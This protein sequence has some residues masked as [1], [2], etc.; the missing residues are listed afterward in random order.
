MTFVAEWARTMSLR[1]ANRANFNADDTWRSDAS[2]VRTPCDGRHELASTTAVRAHA[3]ADCL[4]H[5]RA[6]YRHRA[7]SI[8][9]LP[10][11]FPMTMPAVIGRMIAAIATFLRVD[12]MT[13]AFAATFILILAACPGEGLGAQRSETA[14]PNPSTDYESV[15]DRIRSGDDR[16]PHTTS[17]AWEQGLQLAVLRIDS[18][19]LGE[20]ASRAVNRWPAAQGA[21]E[22][23]WEWARVLV[24]LVQAALIAQGHDPGRPDGLMGPKTMLAMVAWSAASGPAWDGSSE[25]SYVRGLADNVAHLLHGTLQTL[26]LSPG[27]WDRFLGWESVAALERWDGTFRRAGVFI[28]IDEDFGRHVL[29]DELGVSGPTGTGQTAERFTAQTQHRVQ[30]GQESWDE[31]PVDNVYRRHAGR[32]ISWRVLVLQDA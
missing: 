31:C 29:M 5:F 13:M 18:G 30:P 3:Q 4:K 1:F 11:V 20:D 15:S 32:A 16:S 22:P 7:D 24:F 9:L 28:S 14:L 8:S 2:G 6:T 26:G 10:F 25:M 12:A 17:E 23:S 19:K 27:P 21:D